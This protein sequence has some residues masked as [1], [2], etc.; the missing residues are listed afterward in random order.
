MPGRAPL[1]LGG[2]RRVGAKA[3]LPLDGGRPVGGWHVTYLSPRGA[4]RSVAFGKVSR[5][6]PPWETR[7]LFLA[8]MLSCL[9]VAGIF[10]QLEEEA[11]VQERIEMG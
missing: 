10:L 3:V 2:D 8:W 1:T 4:V 7:S 6:R 5:D 11:S 9:G